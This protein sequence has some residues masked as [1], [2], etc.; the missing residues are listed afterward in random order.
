MY[1][2]IFIVF[3]NDI[4]NKKKSTRKATKTTPSLKSEMYTTPDSAPPPPLWGWGIYPN[5]QS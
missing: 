3:T 5:A 2:N 1:A 4:A